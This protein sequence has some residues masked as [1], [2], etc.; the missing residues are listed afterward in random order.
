MKLEEKEVEGVRAKCIPRRPKT[1]TSTS[2]KQ[3]DAEIARAS[4]NN[5]HQN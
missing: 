5:T 2:K 4:I 3:C 1:Q